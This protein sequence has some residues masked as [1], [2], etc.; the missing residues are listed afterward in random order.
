MILYIFNNYFLDDSGFS[1]RCKREI[2]MLSKKDNMLI[3]CRENAQKK[4]NYKINNKEIPIMT[5]NPSLQLLETPSKYTYICYE[6]YRTIKLYISL[7]AILH[8]SFKKNKNKPIIVYVVNSPLTLSFFCFIFSKLYSVRQTILE[9]HDLEPEMAMH[10]KKLKKGNIILTVEFYLEKFLCKAYSKI[11]VTNAVQRD[12]LQKRTGIP[13][14]K[15][16]ILPNSIF[17]EEYK[18]SIKDAYSFPTIKKNDF[19]VGYISTL[20]FDYTFSGLVDILKKMIMHFSDDSNLKFLI[21]GEGKG[22]DFIREIIRKYKLENNILLSGKTNNVA[23]F[24]HRM[25][26]CLIPWKENPFTLSILPTKLF[27]YMAAEKLVIA[28]DFGTFPDVIKNNKNGILYE[29]EDDLSNKILSIQKEERK[30]K[31]LA[32]NAYTSFVSYYELHHFEEKYINFL[33]L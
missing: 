2:D 24:L 5:F 21:V 32:K 7:Y 25:D 27:E 1:K 31:N 28:P 11:I 13:Q 16:F 4:K 23:A 8:V 10:I 3:I 29:S 15:L 20:V 19:V 30:R 17:K 9:F 12:I 33:S 6:V 22:L 14:D 18:H 26:I